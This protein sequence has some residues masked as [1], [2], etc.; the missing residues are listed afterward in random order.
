M[1]LVVDIDEIET[2]SF[3]ESCEVTFE[4]IKMSL[5]QK[6]DKPDRL[7]LD[8]SLKGKASPGRMLAIMGPSGSG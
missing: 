8:G 4:G 7:I 2:N 6:G 3:V 1:Y 5:K